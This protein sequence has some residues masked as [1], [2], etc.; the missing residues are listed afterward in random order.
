[1]RSAHLNHS[2]DLISKTS[3]ANRTGSVTQN[4]EHLLCK[5]NPQP[6][7]REGRG[8]EWEGKEEERSLFFEKVPQP[9]QKEKKGRVTGCGGGEGKGRGREVE[10]KGEGK[11]QGNEKGSTRD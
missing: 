4:V 9:H 2:Q 5:F 10:G 3:R 1:L 6:N 8:V 7:R 11:G